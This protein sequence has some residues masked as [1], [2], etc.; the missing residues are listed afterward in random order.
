MRASTGEARIASGSRTCTLTPPTTVVVAFF[1]SGV[2]MTRS[3]LLRRPRQ[4]RA[5]YAKA[6]RRLAGWCRPAIAGM[7]ELMHA[8]HVRP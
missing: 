5:L 1:R 8:L 3:K 6:P 4:Y 2:M 7:A